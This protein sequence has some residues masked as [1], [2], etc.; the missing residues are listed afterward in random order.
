MF[1]KTFFRRKTNA[2][3]NYERAESSTEMKTFALEH[4]S[5]VALHRSR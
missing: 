4:N 5:L 3:A 2:L 1:L